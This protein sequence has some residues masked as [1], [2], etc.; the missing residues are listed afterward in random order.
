M[1]EIFADG[2][3]SI[4]VA[5]S[6]LVDGTPADFPR[7]KLLSLAAILYRAD[8]GLPIH[9]PPA[10]ATFFV[11]HVRQQLLELPLL[12]VQQGGQDSRRHHQPR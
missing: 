7:A 10:F 12:A 3:G 4:I 6:L 5:L 9:A 1:T 11:E 2:T 8:Q